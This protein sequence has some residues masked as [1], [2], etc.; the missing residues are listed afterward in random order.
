MAGTVVFRA[1]RVITMDPNRPSA[2]HVAVRDGKILAV[3]G[4]EI[5]SAW[6]GGEADDRFSDAILMPGFV[7]GHAH[8][9]AGAMWRYFYAGYQDRIDPEGR[10]WKG[11]TDIDAVID[12][13]RDAESRLDADVPLVGWGFDPIFLRTERLNRSHLDAVS[14]TRPVVIMH[15]N[16]HLKIGRAH[17]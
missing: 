13:L 5:A 15:S 1:R 2:T 4:A 6:G 3:G 14:P 9:M 7:E 8:M 12:G 10:L 11:L 17:V 16:F